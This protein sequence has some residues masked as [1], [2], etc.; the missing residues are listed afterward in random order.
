MCSLHPRTRKTQ[1]WILRS[2][3][4]ALTAFALL[5]GAGAPRAAGPL[6]YCSSAQA[7]CLPVR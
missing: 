6:D 2:S 3:L 7:G 5:L 4:V 1:A